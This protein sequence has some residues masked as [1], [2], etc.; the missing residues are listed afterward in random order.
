MV[1]ILNG[2]WLGSTSD[3]M[4]INF[5]LNRNIKAVIYCSNNPEE[6]TSGFFEI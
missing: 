5:C 1:Q 3:V 4:N 2:I 6:N